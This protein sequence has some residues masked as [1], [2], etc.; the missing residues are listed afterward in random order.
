[1]KIISKEKNCWIIALDKHEQLS[2]VVEAW[3][4]ASFEMAKPAGISA[5]TSYNPRTQ[6]EDVKA[7]ALNRRYAAATPKYL[8]EMDYV[9]GRRCKTTIVRGHKYL[10]IFPGA[11]REQEIET[12]YLLAMKFLAEFNI[13]TQRAVPQTNFIQ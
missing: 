10:T 3:G 13:A 11:D 12:M 1:M 9:A 7:E 2:N 6:W 5:L 4:R 8:L